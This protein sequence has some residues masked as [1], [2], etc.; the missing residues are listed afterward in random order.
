MRAVVITR[1]GGPDVLEVREMPDP[2]PGPGEVRIAVKASG[3]NF[4]DLMARMGLYP[5]A[6]KPPSVVGYEVAGVVDMLGPGVTRW[7]VG[8]RVLSPTM[9]GGYAS[10][11]IAKADGIV[12]LAHGLSFAQGA[13]IPVNYATA[14]Q[15]LHHMGSL[16]AGESV[17]IGAAAGGVGLAAVD[18]V[19]AAG[20]Q[21][22]GQASE[23]KHAFLRERGVK[24]LIGREEA[25]LAGI[26]RLTGGRGVDLFLDSEGG[27]GLRDAYAALA[28]GGRLMMFGVSSLAP[29]SR[30]N[31]FAALNGLLRMPRFKPIDLM[32]D[33]KG[34]LGVNMNS[35]GRA[36]PEL[37][38]RHM[39]ALM[40]LYERG[41]LRPFV[42]AEFPPERAGEAHQLIH[43]RKNRG[44]VVI[45]WP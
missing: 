38:V 36:A 26:R 45:A 14:Y 40:A 19:L 27:P 37:Y 42:D 31:L 18:L 15:L 4:A 8:D 6:P 21:P 12:L 39:Q 10:L 16:K 7:A 28:P 13:A 9:F 2:V 43:D 44:K 3:I 34:V 30:R 41:A 5:E 20:A 11:A 35:L 33:N 23:S 25:A 22:I 29:G 32:N 24:D 1:H 17:Y